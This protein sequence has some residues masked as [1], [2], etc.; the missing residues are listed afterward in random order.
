[1]NVSRKQA[2]QL[3]YD[4]E[5]FLHQDLQ[6]KDPNNGNAP[7]LI[8]GFV[9]EVESGY[10]VKRNTLYRSSRLTYFGRNKTSLPVH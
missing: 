9:R 2:D 4:I 1:M 7:T 3:A 5:L 10:A 6:L 8:H